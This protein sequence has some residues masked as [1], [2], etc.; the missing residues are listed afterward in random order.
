M[1]R[2][3]VGEGDLVVVLGAGVIGLSI[4]LAVARRGPEALVFVEPTEIRRRR[5]AELGLGTAVHPDDAEETVRALRPSGAD[6]VFEATGIL[7]VVGGVSPAGP[8]GRHCRRRRPGSRIVRMPLIV[9][10]RKELTLVGTRNSAG[11]FPPAIELLAGSPEFAR[12]VITHR[13]HPRAAAEAYAE[14][15][16][17][18]TDALK[19]LLSYA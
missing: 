13:F 10:T 2:S 12:S 6:V 9:M 14:L 4:G 8:A 16:T 5:V 3:A 17:P 19:V 18:G 11:D 1:N 15:T 7:G